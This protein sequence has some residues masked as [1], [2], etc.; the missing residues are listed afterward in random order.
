M[1]S[2]SDDDNKLQKK[3]YIYIYMLLFHLSFF[4]LVIIAFNKKKNIEKISGTPLT[5]TEKN[6][7]YH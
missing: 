7:V 2:D 1:L 3:I 4:L 5:H 6:E